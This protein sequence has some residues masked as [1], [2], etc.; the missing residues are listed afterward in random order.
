MRILTRY[1]HNSSC[2]Y[3]F[4]Y[5]VAGG[6]VFDVLSRLEERSVQDQSLSAA[7]KGKLL[8]S[9]ETLEGLTMTGKGSLQNL[10][11]GL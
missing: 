5:L 8:L 11:C 6:G 3:T 9:R 1:L 2:L 10:D 4:H 7:A